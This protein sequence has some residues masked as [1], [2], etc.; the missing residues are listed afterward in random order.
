MADLTIMQESRRILK[1]TRTVQKNSSLLCPIL[2]IL[3]MR[4]ADLDMD[5]VTR[6]V[7]R[8]LDE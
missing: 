3:H 5:Q 8:V 1:Q 6:V 7:K 4:H 2:K